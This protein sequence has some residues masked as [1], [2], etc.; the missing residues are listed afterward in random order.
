MGGIYR[1]SN[2]G[3]LGI[4]TASGVHAVPEGVILTLVT[5][6]VDQWHTFLVAKG[7]AIE[8]APQ[9]NPKFNIYHL[10]LRDPNGY[11]IEIQTFRSPDW[12]RKSVER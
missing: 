8:S 4:C 3:F 7:I 10:F 6:A 9:L 2:D 1:I 11:L 5:D 12:P